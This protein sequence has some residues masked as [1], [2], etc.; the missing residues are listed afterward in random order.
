MK[1]TKPITVS[2]LVHDPRSITPTE[3]RGG[4]WYKREDAF[5]VG[6][7]NGTKLRAA[8]HLISAAKTAGH[9][10]IISAASVISPQNAISATVC[11]S[12]GLQSVT[13]IGGT[14]VPKAVELHETIAEAARLGSEIIAPVRV[15]YNPVLQSAAKTL[16]SSDS[17]YWRLPYGI[18]VEDDTP[19]SLSSFSNQSLPQTENLP[20]SMTDLVLPFGSGNS[21]F[22]VLCGLIHNA[23]RYPHLSSIHLMT[24]GPDRMEQLRERFRL[25]KLSSEFDQLPID[26]VM[27]H[28]NYATY[29]DSMRET[30]D[31]IRF[32]PHYEG[33]IVRYLNARKPAYWTRRDGCTALWIVGSELGVATVDTHGVDDIL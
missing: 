32:H 30:L 6:M 17:R 2:R 14:T 7:V 3:L 15:G 5:R 31:G 25:L 21:A 29:G 33:K 8:Y 22:G 24:V 26:Q 28:P 18:S 20:E 11:K 1:R 12:L 4:M 13:V 19:E 9:S 10:C 27:L 23:N 16:E